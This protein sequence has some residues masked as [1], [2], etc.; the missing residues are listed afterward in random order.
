MLLWLHKWKKSKHFNDRVR[1]FTPGPDLCD[2]WLWLQPN[3]IY[4]CRAGSFYTVSHSPVLNHH[5]F[6]SFYG[7]PF[8]REPSWILVMDVSTNVS[9]S[10][11]QASLNYW[12]H[13][14]S[15]FSSTF[16]ITVLQEFSC[17]SR[18]LWPL[19]KLQLHNAVH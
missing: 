18:V 17:L 12:G 3:P 9:V 15:L 6:N 2:K 19:I 5:R 10:V 11:Y 14:W 7:K 8:L 13:R 16:V 4:M 1:G